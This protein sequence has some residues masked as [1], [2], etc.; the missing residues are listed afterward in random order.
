M[1]RISTMEGTRI[2]RWIMEE[3]LGRANDGDREKS[4]VMEVGRSDNGSPGYGV[5]SF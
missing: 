5:H 4:L 3:S 1:N 2:M